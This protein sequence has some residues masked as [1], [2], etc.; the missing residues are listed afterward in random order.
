MKYKNISQNYK[1]K[2]HARTFNILT[3]LLRAIGA[4]DIIISQLHNL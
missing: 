4:I 3:P 2:T 1:K